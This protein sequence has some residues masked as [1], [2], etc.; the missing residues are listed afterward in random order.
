MRTVRSATALEHHYE[1]ELRL[2]ERLRG[3]APGERASTYQAVYDELF[4]SVPDHPQLAVDPAAR[5]RS[6]AGRLRFVRRF[7]GPTST[8]LEIGAGDC[9]FARAAAP[10]VARVHAVDVSEEIVRLSGLPAN[11]EVHLVHGVRLPI[12]DASVQVAFSDQL[13]EHFAADDARTHLAEVRRVLG[14]G[15]VYVCITPNRTTGPHDISALHD[16]VARGFHLREYDS[17]ELASLVRAAGFDAVR[18]YAGGAGHYGEVPTALL[19]RLE[20]LVGALPPHARRRLGGSLP[21]YVLLGLNAV[22]SVK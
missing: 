3:A 21:A 13:M 12:A 14:P 11:V 15:G 16:D 20:R 6:V 8:L 18:F 7:C 10:A 9:A 22:A 1:V 4:R 19:G 2:A 17:A 5:A